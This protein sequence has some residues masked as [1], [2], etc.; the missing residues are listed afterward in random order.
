MTDNIDGAVSVARRKNS[1]APDNVASVLIF[2]C[3]LEKVELKD[4][5]L[6]KG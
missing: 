1:T 4:F 3:I 2:H 6:G 5:F